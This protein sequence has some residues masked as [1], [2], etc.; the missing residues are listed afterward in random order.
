[1]RRYQ[2]GEAGL[3]RIAT[4]K[5]PRLELN[6]IDKPKKRARHR[7]RSPEINLDINQQA[8]VPA[9][10]ATYDFGEM[11]V[12]SEEEL[13]QAPSQ[14]TIIQPQRQLV[15]DSVEADIAVIVNMP[16]VTVRAPLY[17]DDTWVVGEEQYD[18]GFTSRSWI[19]DI[20]VAFKFSA[21][22]GNLDVEAVGIMAS[23]LL[24]SEPLAQLTWLPLRPGRLQILFNCF[25]RQDF[26]YSHVLL[27]NTLELAARSPTERFRV[28]ADSLNLWI[29]EIRR[30]YET[31][32]GSDENTFFEPD[33]A[34][35]V[36]SIEIIYY[37]LRGVR[38]VDKANIE[39]DRL[40]KNSRRVFKFT[41]VSD[42]CGPNAL[43][44]AMEVNQV[45]AWTS[46][47]YTQCSI[48]EEWVDA[49]WE[50]AASKYHIRVWVWERLYDASKF[51]PAH[52]YGRV[53]D[54]TICHV[55]VSGGHAEA[56]QLDAHNR[57]LI[58]RL[59]LCR[60]CFL[61]FVKDSNHFSTCRK[62]GCG[63]LYVQGRSNHLLTCK[64]ART[65]ELERALG[66]IKIY[67]KDDDLEGESLFFAD[68]ETFPDADGNHQVYAASYVR[69]DGQPITHIGRDAISWFVEEMLKYDNR[70]IWFFYNG[71]AFDVL[72]ILREWLTN[73]GHL[74]E[75]M[76]NEQ[77]DYVKMK[78]S[79]FISVKLKRKPIVEIRDLMLLLSTVRLED[80]AKAFAG[81]TEQKGDLDHS[82]FRSWE[83]VDTYSNEVKIYLEKDVIATRGVFLGYQ[84][85]IWDGFHINLAKFHTQAQL[86]YAMW[87]TKYCPNGNENCK[88][89][90]ST[91]TEYPIHRGALYGGRVLPIK[92]HFVSEQWDNILE[93]LDKY[94][95]IPDET[96]DS[97]QDFIVHVDQSSQYP[98]VMKKYEYPVGQSTMLLESEH[99]VMVRALGNKDQK[100]K[101][102]RS[103]WCVDTL[104]PKD[105]LVP[106]LMHREKE[107]LG[108]DLL[109]HSNQI[110][111][112]VDIWMAHRLGYT[113]PKIYYIMLWADQQDVFS[114]YI[115][116][117]YEGKAKAARGGGDYMMYKISMN[118][119]SGKYSQKIIR[120]SVHL[121][122]AAT[123]EK[124]RGFLKD[125]REMT[126][127]YNTDDELMA[128]LIKRNLPEAQTNPHYPSYLT[129]F[130][131]AYAR[132]LMMRL[133]IRIN[134]HKDIDRCFYYTDTDSYV[135]HNS[136]MPH[137]EVNM[138]KG[139]GKFEDEYGGD[140]KIVWAMFLGKKTYIEAYVQK[141]R[142]LVR[143]RCKGIPHTSATI[144]VQ[145]ERQD[146]KEWLADMVRRLN[147]EEEYVDLRKRC[148][149]ATPVDSDSEEPASVYSY[150]TMDCFKK[151]YAGTHMIRCHYGSIKRTI[152][153]NQPG[154]Q[155]KPM[156]MAR[157]LV[158]GEGLFWNRGVRIFKEGDGDHVNSYP[159]GYE[160]PE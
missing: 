42:Q 43:A 134:G 15:I 157:A 105:I 124:A 39:F 115:D 48:N 3:E 79:R 158:G 51:Y 10:Y 152:A 13:P 72:F 47:I 86:A 12:D 11:R 76:E 94:G 110:Y 8:Q 138:G 108:A 59:R 150:L 75:E 133:L 18:L 112:G 125:D 107:K 74:V 129:A 73:H 88:L 87:S 9:P 96:F 89:Y 65:Y 135:F 100:Y 148:Y 71:S 31:G 106:Y 63:F 32:A 131:T 139:L 149:V 80:A 98:T 19:N 4:R 26:T 44:L 49:S 23:T 118:G 102:L 119:V 114:S 145:K 64:R 143:V 103:I 35:T 70:G 33:N 69:L 20:M 6:V 151:A 37:A 93:A 111:T 130:I 92:T 123:I 66:K 109:P 27:L 132:K 81:I 57:P 53:E 50:L 147:G 82:L 24:A 34:N 146:S 14:P 77:M 140:A 61:Y 142:L 156:F 30:R 122:P 25:N 60:V 17:I 141:K 160:F 127:I 84:K 128:M 5:R 121:V 137:F 40:L 154:L 52:K 54:S 2:A 104:P 22:L 78:G 91:K 120:E 68:F 28:I 90:V 7:E 83:D 41:T 21:D 97:I 126:P 46:K 153:G 58:R 62:C 159:K 29:E 16:F 99:A 116:L 55:F 45:E 95:E 67:K 56:L 155:L 1:M 38:C 144:D 85:V 136:V 117:C 113:F 101:I 36:T